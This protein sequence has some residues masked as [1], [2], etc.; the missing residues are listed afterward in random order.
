MQEG[1]INKDKIS[2]DDE[3]IYAQKSILLRDFKKDPI[4][5]INQT[6]SFFNHMIHLTD[7]KGLNGLMKHNI[8]D[9]MASIHSSFCELL[10]LT[11]KG[12][13]FVLD[14]TGVNHDVDRM[15]FDT[16]ENNCD[17]MMNSD[18]TKDEKRDPVFKKNISITCIETLIL[19][20]LHYLNADGFDQELYHEAIEYILKQFYNLL[21]IQFML[22]TIFR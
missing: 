18:A 1:F 22:A 11:N 14:A 21:R 15:I 9:K 6:C 4:R 12:E 2:K 17:Q 16:I 10:H 19:A 8:V 5:V 7:L 13:H 3:K 20:S